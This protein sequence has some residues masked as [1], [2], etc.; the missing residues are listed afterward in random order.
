MKDWSGIQQ[1]SIRIIMGGDFRDNRP[2][3]EG[4]TPGDPCETFL[5]NAE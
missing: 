3:P 2:P 5:N 1:G 4:K